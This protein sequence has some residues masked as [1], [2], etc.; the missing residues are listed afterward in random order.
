MSRHSHDSERSP[1]GSSFLGYPLEGGRA[2]PELVLE[3]R[4]AAGGVWRLY[5][6][7]VAAAADVRESGYAAARGPGARHVVTHAINCGAA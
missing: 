6:G 1:D 2:N 4:K 5:C 7:N 3:V